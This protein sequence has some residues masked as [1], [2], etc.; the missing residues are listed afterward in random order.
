MATAKELFEN[1]LNLVEI[2][3]QNFRAH[4]GLNTLRAMKNLMLQTL[5]DAEEYHKEEIHGRPDSG[6]VR[7]AG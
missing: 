7:Q 6:T 3:I 4:P 1:D 5:I 2:H